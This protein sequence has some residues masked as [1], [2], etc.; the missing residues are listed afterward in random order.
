MPSVDSHAA[1]TP[2]WVD[3]STPD[4]EGARR[5]YGA[6]FGWEFLVGPEEARYYTMC[7]LG[8]RKVAGMSLKDPAIPGRAYWELAFEAAD[9]Q[10]LAARA[11]ELGGKLVVPPTSASG[12][13]TF[14]SIVD[15][16]GARFNLWQS[17]EHQGAQVVREP[18]SMAW[19]EVNT[20]DGVRAKDFYAALF[21]LEARKLETAMDYW[22]L[23]QGGEPVAGVLQMNEHWPKDLPPHWMNYF[24]VTNTDASAEQVRKLGGHVHVGPMD[25]PYGRFCVVT[26]PAG[27]GFTLTQPVSPTP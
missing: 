1:G 6:L 7:Q 22:T 24:V 17:G 10:S 2:A 8:G 21:G 11:V 27:A 18:G 5:F 20:R 3:L 4:L 9:T 14:A 25:S 15:P 12:Q 26:D 16:T 23:H 13:G 19:H